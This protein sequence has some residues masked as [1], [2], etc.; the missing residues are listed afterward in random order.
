[1]SRNIFTLGISIVCITVIC[2]CYM[3]NKCKKL[4]EEAHLCSGGLTS[5]LLVHS[6]SE[7]AQN[8]EAGQQPSILLLFC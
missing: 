2:K 1:M 7:S 8:V 4:G 5:S 6:P 3:E